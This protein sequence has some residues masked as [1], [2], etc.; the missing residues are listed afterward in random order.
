MHLAW[1]LLLAVNANSRVW[2]VVLLLNAALIGLATVGSGE[3]YFVD[4]IAAVPFAFGVQHLTEKLRVWTK[5]SK[6]R[7]HVRA[8][9]MPQPS[10]VRERI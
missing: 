4:L 1:A 6:D 9:A 8:L 5:T 2:K 3:H 7:S 10:E